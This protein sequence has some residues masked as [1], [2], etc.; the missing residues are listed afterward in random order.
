MIHL[1]Q[2]DFCF[3]LHQ[4]ICKS[5]WRWHTNIYTN[6]YVCVF[7]MTSDWG[8]EKSLVYGCF[9]RILTHHPKVDSCNRHTPLSGTSLKDSSKGKSYQRTELQAGHPDALDSKWE[10]VGVCVDSQVVANG[11]PGW[12]GTWKER[13]WKSGN[14]EI[15]RR[16]MWINFSER[17]KKKWRYVCFMWMITNGLL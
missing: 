14:K 11:L 9:C 2:N 1:G 8:R 3:I 16:G 13:D 6:I 12:L 15:W 4:F 5:D 10:E 7:C 17:E